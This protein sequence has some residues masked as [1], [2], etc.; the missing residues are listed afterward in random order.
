MSISKKI[1]F[2]L[3]VFIVI[4]VSGH[5]FW[6]QPDKFIYNRTEPVNIRLL[7]GQNFNGENWTGNR[8]KIN[9]IELY[10]DDVVDKMLNANFG[11][12]PGDSLQIAMIDEG[13]VMV[14]LN[15][16]DSLIRRDTE[17]PDEV[18]TDSTRANMATGDAARADTTTAS[19]E[20][21][22][23][24]AK[25]LFQ[26]GTRF[27]NVYRKKT[28]LPLDIIPQDNPY[29]VTK[30]GKFKIQIFF[31]GEKLKNWKVKVWHKVD[32]KVSVEDYTTDEDG[33][34]KLFLSPQGEWMVSCLKIFRLENDLDA[35]WQRHEGTLTW[36]YY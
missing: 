29:A 6:M 2:L 30:D 3:P 28:G 19:R 23:L 12:G 16:K 18:L 1:S 32:D 31:M 5:E 36:G 25:T 24:S 20:K 35:Q 27:T 10:F 7:S 11:D 26:V 13:T 8:E 4:N 22:Q 21:Y 17:N 33:A 14:T 9:H 34:L 15:T